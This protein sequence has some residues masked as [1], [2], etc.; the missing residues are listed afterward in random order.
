[1]QKMLHVMYVTNMT[2]IGMLLTF[3][4]YNTSITIDFH[5]IFWYKV[6]GKQFERLFC[7]VPVLTRIVIVICRFKLAQMKTI[8]FIESGKPWQFKI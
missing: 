7:L 4:K 5:I 6:Y 3:V 1:M 8:D 2:N